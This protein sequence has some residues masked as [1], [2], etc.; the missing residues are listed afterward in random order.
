VLIQGFPY[1][2]L[3]HDYAHPLVSDLRMAGRIN[4]EKRAGG[5][6]Q[7]WVPSEWSG[8]LPQLLAEAQPCANAEFE[9]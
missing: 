2:F 8:I 7:I 5:K 3:L 9:K 4:P 6:S 1:L